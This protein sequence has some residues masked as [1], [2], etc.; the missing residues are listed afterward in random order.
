MAAGLAA[1][2]VLLAA[3]GRA[4][5]NWMVSVAAGSAQAG[6]GG[7]PAAPNGVT[8][9][10]AGPESVTVGW[11]PVS[12]ASTYTVYDSVDGGGYA[13]LA[14]GVPGTSYTATL[15]PPSHSYSFEVLA[16]AGASWQGAASPPS[17]TRDI[18]GTGGCL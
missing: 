16:V 17:A 1:A 18:S 4:P 8:A 5:A 12:H 10:C 3:A 7:P 9:T 2:V 14:A 13:P 6:A 15:L 11:G